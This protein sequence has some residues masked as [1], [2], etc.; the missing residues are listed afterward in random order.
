MGLI[1]VLIIIIVSSYMGSTSAKT[2]KGPRHN[3]V[4]SPSA[5]W[6]DYQHLSN[7]SSVQEAKKYADT[8]GFKSFFLC[9]TTQTL[10]KYGLVPE[11]SFIFF[12]FAGGPLKG[13]R[14]C[15]YYESKKDIDE[16]SLN[17][18]NCHTNAECQNTPGWFTC[19]CKPGFIGN[20]VFCADILSWKTV[21]NAAPA[22]TSHWGDYR[23]VT[24]INVV[25]AKLLAQENGYKSFFLC[26]DEKTFGKYGYFREDTAVFFSSVHNEL[27]SALGCNYYSRIRDVNECDLGTDDCD[28]N[29]D[30]INTLGSYICK[31]KQGYTGDGNMCESIYETRV[32]AYSSMWKPPR[33]AVMSKDYDWE[34]YKK[35]RNMSV[36]KSKTFGA[37]NNY[38]SFFI[39][40]REYT[41]GRYGVIPRNTTVFFRFSGGELSGGPGCLYFE[42][43]S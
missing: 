19:K 23:T 29:A 20:G 9:K 30:C 41:L 36:M 4:L 24:Q 12:K 33:V 42:R 37:E 2:W 1:K 27:R 28:V 7:I 8:H 34:N 18:N 43:V 22:I 6:G 15:D 38:R 40:N 17:I 25:S 31:C 3:A 26:D 32:N 14:G 35:L 13:V 11:S 21:H 16:C 39:C 5:D 10:E